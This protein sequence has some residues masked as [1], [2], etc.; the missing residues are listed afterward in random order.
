[1]LSSPSRVSQCQVIWELGWCRILN[2]TH[3]QLE[4]IGWRNWRSSLKELSPPTSVKEVRS[5]KS[6]CWMKYSDFT[7]LNPEHPGPDVMLWTTQAPPVCQV[8]MTLWWV[9]DIYYLQLNMSIWLWATNGSTSPPTSFQLRQM[10]V[11]ELTWVWSDFDS[12]QYV[13]DTFV[14]CITF[15]L[16]YLCDFVLPMNQLLFMQVFNSERWQFLT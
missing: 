6:W 10:L 9:C 12:E 13:C 11:F 5:R 4:K 14:I 16:T 3:H 8:E 15:N 1:M 2:G 7:D